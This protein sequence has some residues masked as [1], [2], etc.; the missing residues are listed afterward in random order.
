MKAILYLSASL[1]LFSSIHT[2]AQSEYAG[3]YYGELDEE[4]QAF[5]HTVVPRKK[6]NTITATVSDTGALTVTGISG[7]S[8]Q[9]DASGTISFF[10]NGFGFSTGT[11]S[12]NTLNAAGQHEQDG[13]VRVNKYWIVATRNT[14]VTSAFPDATPE[15]N[16]WNYTPWFG[17]FNGESFPWIYHQTLGPMYVTGSDNT[18]LW[19]YFAPLGFIFTNKDTYPWFYDPQL[20]AWLFYDT[21]IASPQWFYNQSTTTWFS[22]D[23]N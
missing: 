6:T 15:A 17:F 22:V 18:A 4:V 8:G 2:H 10:Q 19:M 11:I 3:T 9:V 13:G 16:N 20:D 12:G 14:S 1:L 23:N 21:S 5:G 7:V